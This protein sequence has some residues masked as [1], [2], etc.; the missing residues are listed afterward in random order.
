MNSKNKTL[1]V[2]FVSLVVALKVAAA[3][4]KSFG[5]PSTSAYAPR[6]V[7]NMRTTNMMADQLNLLRE[8]PLEG[9][10]EL[11]R[12]AF[13]QRTEGNSSSDIERQI[14]KKVATG[15]L[16][17]AMTEPE[18]VRPETLQLLD[19]ARPGTD[20][21]SIAKMIDGV[22]HNNKD[23]ITLTTI[24]RIKGKLGRLSAIPTAQDIIALQ[25]RFEA[26][27]SGAMAQA[28]T[29]VVMAPPSKE[30]LTPTGLFLK[31][32]DH[33][34]LPID[35]QRALSI[36]P[37]RRFPH[38]NSR[39]ESP[40]FLSLGSKGLHLATTSEDMMI[41]IFRVEDGRRISQAK[42]R[43]QL[44]SGGWS[45]E[46]SAV[47]PDSSFFVTM[48]GPTAP[49]AYYD[50]TDLSKSQIL[51]VDGRPGTLED[52]TELTL[53]TPDS[54]HILAIND[55]G[56]IVVWTKTRSGFRR[57]N[58]VLAKLSPS[59]YIK[60]GLRSAA[61][62]PDGQTLVLGFNQ[63]ETTGHIAAY[64]MSDIRGIQGKN[65]VLPKVSAEFFNTPISKVQFTQGGS[66]SLMAVLD[67]RTVV[68]LD[69]QSLKLKKRL[70][71]TIG[72]AVQDLLT[73]N[74]NSLITISDSPE[75][76]VN[77]WS[78][79]TGKLRAMFQIERDPKSHYLSPSSGPFDPLTSWAL[80]PDGKYLATGSDGGN[81]SVWEV[82]TG[83]LV[84]TTR[85]ESDIR[86]LAF[87]PD[88]KY[89]ATAAHVGDSRLFDFQSLL[90]W[91][92]PPSSR[93]QPVPY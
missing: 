69:W 75:S 67:D 93:R 54:R 42:S 86:G 51:N 70:V 72:S 20:R 83:N 62:S 79:K 32:V 21:G 80:S 23:Q 33:F 1:V 85:I 76:A 71:G 81:L 35:A 2:L 25:V 37:L 8:S 87:S 64:S 61:L 10:V 26:L 4:E 59:S 5:I 19:W 82:E 78:R 14:G 60:H 74:T 7:A 68:P 28:Q 41:R 65:T 52:S 46:I 22:M 47:A 13:T 40:N 31:R 43:H 30:K 56:E 84:T 36:P 73:G 39:V 24:Q 90:R 58:S 27:Y 9:L 16:Y 89:L 29:A 6:V 66:L 44:G 15:L 53:V 92:M 48:G 88:G 3:S 57:S 50:P 12:L 11:E 77:I 38:K 49:V 63:P 91:T 34:L 55:S 18:A 17:I 45:A